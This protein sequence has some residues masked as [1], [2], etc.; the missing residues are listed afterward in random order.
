MTRTLHLVGALLAASLA[1]QSSAETIYGLA[2]AGINQQLVTFDSAG[3]AVTNAA[4]ISGLTAGLGTV[5]LQSIDV[6]PATGELYGLDNNSLLYSINPVSGAAT[7][8]GVQL[9]PTPTGTTS[10]RTIDF[11][12]TVDRIRVLG[13]SPSNNNLRVNPSTGATLVDGTLAFAA[14]DVNFG[15]RPFVVGGA[16]TNSDRDPATGTTLY[17]IEAGL[18]ILVTQTPANDGTLQTVGPLGLTVSNTGQV[19]FDISGSTGL[20]YLVGSQL[21]GGTISANTLY[22]VNLA[23]GAATSL[24]SITGVPSGSVTDIAVAFPGAPVPEPTSITLGVL[25]VGGLLLG[26]RRV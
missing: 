18:D 7:Q 17:D 11:N 23:T 12:P 4:P 15:T 3:L 5:S 16:Y 10:T 8:V 20:A 14:G 9:S 25:L 2:G 22:S 6:R 1:G 21:F 26:R 19:S 13:D 24:G